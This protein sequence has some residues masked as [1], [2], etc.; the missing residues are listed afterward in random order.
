MILGGLVGSLAAFT[1][2][3]DY[4]SLT[5]VIHEMDYDKSKKL[6]D[7]LQNV[8]TTIDLTDIVKFTML[9]STSQ[10]IKQAVIHETINFLRNE[11]HMQIAN[12]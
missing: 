3:P 5:Q 8:M 11:L 4:K 1:I 7:V 12:Q 9:L 2:I 6:F 10:S